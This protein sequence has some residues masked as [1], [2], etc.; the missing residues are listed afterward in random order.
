[1]AAWEYRST[2]AC[3]AGRRADRDAAE[4]GQDPLRHALR[5]VARDRVPDL[6]A[7]DR[8]E[9]RVVLGD[10]EQ[11]GVDADLA[12]GQGERVGLGV[13]EQGELPVPLGVAADRGDPPT[14]RLDPLVQRGIAR[15]LLLLLDLLVRLQA[16]VGV[17]GFG[18]QDQLTA[19]GHGR[20]RAGGDGER[21]RQTDQ[22]IAR[23]AALP[24]MAPCHWSGTS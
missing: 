15:D 18:Q 20:L 13:V 16:H 2:T 11:P 23:R 9:L 17:L 10:L 21:E 19:P 6:V 12:A 8:G 7:H 22:R 24:R 3:A 5:A 14:H 4:L 1:M